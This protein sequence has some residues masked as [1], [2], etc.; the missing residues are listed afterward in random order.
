[1]RGERRLGRARQAVPVD[2]AGRRVRLDEGLGAGVVGR[3]VER[4]HDFEH[5]AV[6]APVGLLMDDARGLADAVAHRAAFD[7]A[8]LRV[9][10]DRPPDSTYDLDVE[11][12]MMPA[13]AARHRFGRVADAGAPAPAGRVL[14]AEVAVFQERAQPVALE[15]CVG[16]AGDGEFVHQRFIPCRL[17]HCLSPFPPV[18]ERCPACWPDYSLSMRA[19]RPR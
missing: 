18:S 11:G 6:G 12:V 16:R 5:V 2:P 14:D 19:M 4:R 9:F 15:C 1:M 17:C 7:L 8:E 3:E 13:G 10:E